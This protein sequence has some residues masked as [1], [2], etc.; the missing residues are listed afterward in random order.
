MSNK[1][2]LLTVGAL[3]ALFTLTLAAADGSAA[4]GPRPEGHGPHLPP[5]LR[6]QYDLNQDGKL[7]ETERAALKADVDSG[8]LALPKG[9][10]GGR[11]GEKLTGNPEDH[12]RPV[13]LIAKD[14]GVTP[15]QFRAAFKQVHPARPGTQP[16][17]EQRE[18]NRTALATALGVSP[19]KLDEVM[20]K[21]R[22][23]GKVGHRPEG[24]PE[25]RPGGPGGP[26]GRSRGPSPEVLGKYDLNQDGKLD[27][28]E[29][30]QLQADIASGAFV[31]P[32]RPHPPQAGESTRPEGDSGSAP[33]P[34]H[35]QPRN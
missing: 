6:E 5:Q 11:P 32:N 8:K 4:R 16:T 22:P 12:G 13:D 24:R 29:R 2:P 30:A 10:P 33:R 35:K 17:E 18:A 19:E 9:R 21:Y 26:G 31:P 15:E 3:A 1:F 34:K 28:V 27:E 23:E 25:G 20:D 7:D 14:L